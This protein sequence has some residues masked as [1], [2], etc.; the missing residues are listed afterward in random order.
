MARP[1]IK[2]PTPRRGRPPKIEYVVRTPVKYSKCLL[3]SRECY[4]VWPD[5]NYQALAYHKGEVVGCFSFSLDDEYTRTKKLKSRGLVA[6]GTSVAKPYRNYGIATK[7]WEAAIKLTK[8]TYV[9]V[10]TVTQG[11][12]ALVLSLSKK[13]PK[14]DW[15]DVIEHYDQ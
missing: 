8:P 7:L 2:K 4:G 3:S 5:E 11:G 12:K 13:Y 1:R 10:T 15:M 6:A 9:D 14:I